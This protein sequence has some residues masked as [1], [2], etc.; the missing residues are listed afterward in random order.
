MTDLEW[1]DEPPEKRGHYWIDTDKRF[2]APT[3]IAFSEYY[4]VMWP[5][6]ERWRSLSDYPNASW[7]GPIPEPTE[8]DG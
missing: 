3:I 5:G 7:A 8:P 1:T 2:E 4:D 6:D